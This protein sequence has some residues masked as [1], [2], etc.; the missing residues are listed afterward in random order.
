MFKLSTSSTN[1]ISAINL[2]NLQPS[3]YL[4]QWYFFVHQWQFHYCLDLNDIIGHLKHEVAIDIW[5]KITA[6]VFTTIL[7]H[8]YQQ[9]AFLP[10][11]LQEVKV[12]KNSTNYISFL[13]FFLECI[14][15]ATP[16]YQHLV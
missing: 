16:N 10:N 5:L 9:L 8:L 4:I 12:F 1:L 3:Q 2:D 6:S 13:Y 7:K 11:I 15:H 14:Q